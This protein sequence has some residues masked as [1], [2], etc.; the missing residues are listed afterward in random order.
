LK[1]ELEKESAE[2]IVTNEKLHESEEHYKS[3]FNLNPS[4]MWVLDSESFRFL[5][6]NE[7]A[8]KNYGYT[9]EEFLSMTV[10]DIKMEDDMEE[11]EN[12]LK[13]NVQQGNP[14]SIFTR[15]RRKN[16]EEFY[17]EVIFNRIPFKGKTGIL[18]IAEDITIQVDYIKAIEIQNDKLREIAWIQSH[19]VRS[20]LSTILGLVDLLNYELP[21]DELKETLHGILVSAQKLDNVIRETNENTSAYDLSSKYSEYVKKLLPDNFN[22]NYRS[23]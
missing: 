7:A 11:F 14:L 5:Q 9:N 10:E 12:D 18:T 3:L 2:K 23:H 6:V 4:P 19:K 22:I 15:H 1:K 16:K 13:K 21:E 8:I 17:V 20:P